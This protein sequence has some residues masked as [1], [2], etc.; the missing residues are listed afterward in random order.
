[1]NGRLGNYNEPFVSAE[2]PFPSHLASLS[3]LISMERLAAGETTSTG[4]KKSVGLNR[5]PVACRQAGACWENGRLT[6]AEGQSVLTQLRGERGFPS[7][8]LRNIASVLRT[9]AREG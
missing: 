9:G 6:G 7:T 5:Q 4:G 1:M 3:H 8:S 2:E